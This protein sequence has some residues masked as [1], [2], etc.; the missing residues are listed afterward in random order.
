MYMYHNFL[1]HSSVN[2][3][4]GCFYDLTI[5]NSAPGNTGT[6]ISFLMKVL[7]GEMPRSGI[8]GSHGSSI[9]SFMMYL[10]TVQKK[11]FVQ[12]T[13]ENVLPMFYSRNFMVTSLMLKS[14]SHF[15]FIFVHG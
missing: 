4:F 13:S 10:N 9:F 12:L 8:A 2:G 15:E 11:I 14:L 7:S 3:F 6:H 5:V 1:I